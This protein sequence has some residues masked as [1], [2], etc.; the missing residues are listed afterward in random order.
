MPLISIITP[1]YNNEKYVKNAVES[2]LRQ[3]FDDYE[4]IIVDDGSTDNTPQIVDEIAGKDKRIRVIHQKNQWIY[5]SFN[6]GIKEAA[7]K[8]VYILNSDDRMREGMLAKMV[9]IVKQYGPD[10]VCGEKTENHGK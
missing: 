8:Y 6:N 3:G 1:V 4:Y 2:V 7:G 10:V 5:A 9:Q